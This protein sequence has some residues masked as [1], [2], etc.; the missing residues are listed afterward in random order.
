[1]QDNSSIALWLNTWAV[2]LTSYVIMGRLSNHFKSQFLTLLSWK[3]SWHLSHRIVMKNA[4]TYAQKIFN[5]V[6]SL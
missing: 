6:L 2:S 5:T 4:W 3:N 1:M